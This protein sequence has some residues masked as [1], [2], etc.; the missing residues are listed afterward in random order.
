[1]KTPIMMPV[2]RTLISSKAYLIRLPT[3]KKTTMNPAVKIKIK[4]ADHFLSML[5]PPRNDYDKLHVEQSS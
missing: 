5:K 1:M 4:M 3:G 2:I